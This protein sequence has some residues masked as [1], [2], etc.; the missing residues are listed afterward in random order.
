MVYNT[1]CN[2]IIQKKYWKFWEKRF[3]SLL[4]NE[5]ENVE[6]V[7]KKKFGGSENLKLKKM[8]EEF[9]S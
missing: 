5:D 6:I 9:N 1:V 2:R 4:V 8:K 3:P 7:N